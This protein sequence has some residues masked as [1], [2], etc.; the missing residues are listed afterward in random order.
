[1]LL[2]L[3]GYEAK[4]AHTGPDGVQA[5][6]EWQPDV[7]I[8]DIGL[9]GMDGFTVARRL[10]QAPSIAGVRL[11]ALTGYGQKEDV[12]NARAAGFDDLLVKP[13][14]PAK[15]FD[16][17]QSADAVQHGPHGSGGELRRVRP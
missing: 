8:C 3:S 17:L 6:D 13:T 11:I 10:R 15:L 1:M 2:K 12:A 5:A 16:T 4:L 9:P 7:V 14:D